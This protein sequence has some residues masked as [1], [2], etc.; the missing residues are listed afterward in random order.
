MRRSACILTAL[1]WLC[2]FDAAHAQD[3][4]FERPDLDR[5]SYGS[6]ISNAE[7]G[8]DE[9]CAPY[10]SSNSSSRH[11]LDR[12][13]RTVKFAE[14]VWWEDIQ[15]SFAADGYFIKSSEGSGPYS[16]GSDCNGPRVLLAIEG[17]RQLGEHVVVLIL[18]SSWSSE[19]GLCP[20]KIIV[21]DYSASDD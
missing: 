2:L 14:G 9:N 18:F 8:F 16:G 21:S 6:L 5:E 17:C 15:A 7:D 19:P 3:L 12:K 11:L 13:S 1:I 10:S 4:L 20:G